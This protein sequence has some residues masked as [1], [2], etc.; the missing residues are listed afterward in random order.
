MC[1]C[2]RQVVRQNLPIIRVCDPFIT[3]IRAIKTSD[4]MSDASTGITKNREDK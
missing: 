3:V 4:E 2:V 1:S